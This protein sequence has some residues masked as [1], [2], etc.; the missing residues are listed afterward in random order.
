MS[1]RIPLPRTR[2]ALVPCLYDSICH[3]SR[4]CRRLQAEPVDHFTPTN[5]IRNVALVRLV[6]VGGSQSRVSRSSINIIL[7]NISAFLGDN[8]GTKVVD[9]KLGSSESSDD[10]FKFVLGDTVGRPRKS[11]YQVAQNSSE[12]LLVWSEL[13]SHSYGIIEI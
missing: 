3:F 10:V 5:R 1:L 7:E 8:R 6:Q 11:C 4:S 9:N 2:P 13:P 12:C